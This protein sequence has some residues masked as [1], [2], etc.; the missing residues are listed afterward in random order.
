MSAS[1]NVVRRVGSRNYYARIAVPKDLQRRL[2]KALGKPKREFWKSL[3]TSDPREAKRRSRPVLDGWELEIR[4]LR[5]P[6][7]LTE[8]ELQDAVWRRYL[9]FDIRG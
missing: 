2:G 4:E 7:Q 1:T 6:R 3:D 8:A 5:R 9:E